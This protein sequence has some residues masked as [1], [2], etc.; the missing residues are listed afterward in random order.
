[1]VCVSTITNWSFRSDH[2][3]HDCLMYVTRVVHVI[4]FA[5]RNYKRMCMM[6]GISCNDTWDSDD[7]QCMS[8]FQ[9][10]ASMLDAAYP[11]HGPGVVITRTLF[12]WYA[13][14]VWTPYRRFSVV[15]SM[16]WLGPWAWVWAWV[17]FYHIFD[18][19]RHRI[20]NVC[21][22]K[23]CQLDDVVGWQSLVRLWRVTGVILTF[24][25]LGK[26]YFPVYSGCMMHSVTSQCEQAQAYG[27]WVTACS[28]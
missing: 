17:W 25:Y 28:G 18:R 19:G 10:T 13:V 22:R 8:L 15:T 3:H 21:A 1:M 5:I 27:A 4:L 23:R 24:A 7:R 9:L 16:L 12:T 6:L 11:H 26:S 2:D 14:Y 20:N